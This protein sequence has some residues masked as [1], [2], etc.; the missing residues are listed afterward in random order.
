MVAITFFIP[1]K[2]LQSDRNIII[3][4]IG[5]I[6]LQLLVFTP[7]G[8]DLNGARGRIVLP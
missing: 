1:V 7:L 3:I 5:A 2:R 8:I 4:G 6:I